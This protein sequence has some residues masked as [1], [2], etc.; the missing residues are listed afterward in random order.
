MPTGRKEEQECTGFWNV[1]GSSSVGVG[2][3]ELGGGGSGRHTLKVRGQGAVGTAWASAQDFRATGGGG[4]GTPTRGQVPACSQLAG[5]SGIQDP[6]RRVAERCESLQRGKEATILGAVGR[7]LRH[8][9]ALA[10][11]GHRP[12]PGLPGL[13]LCVEGRGCPRGLKGPEACP[14]RICLLRPDVEAWAVGRACPAPGRAEADVRGGNV[15]R[16]S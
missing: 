7:L 8:P 12:L 16:L 1:L 2:R 11:P 14:S 10:Q 4:P 6:P 3:A 13:A 15:V 5:G 9:P